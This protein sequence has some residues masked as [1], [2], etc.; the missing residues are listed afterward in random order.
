MRT[1]T[2]ARARAAR[3][4]VSCIYIAVNQRC[5]E[6]SFSATFDPQNNPLR[7]WLQTPSGGQAASGNRMPSMPL[8]MRMS[9]RKGQLQKQLTE[10]Q[11]KFDA[12]QLA[13]D[14]VHV[15]NASLRQSLNVDGGNS[16]PSAKLVGDLRVKN[17]TVRL[18]LLSTDTGRFFD[19]GSGV[20]VSGEGHVLTAAHTFL[21]MTEQFP[22]NGQLYGLRE[23][24]HVMIVVGLYQSEGEAARWRHRAELLTPASLLR[25]KVGFRSSSSRQVYIDLAVLRI[26]GDVELDP[27]TWAPSA[28]WYEA[29]ESC[30]RPRRAKSQALGPRVT[31][32]W[33]TPTLPG[34]PPHLH[35][36][37]GNAEAAHSGDE[38]VAAGW[39]SPDAQQAIYVDRS[40]LISR[41]NGFLKSRLFLHAAFSGDKPHSNSWNPMGLPSLHVPRMSPG[42]PTLATGVLLTA[43]HDSQVGRASTLAARSSASPHSTCTPTHQCCTRAG[44][45]PS[46]S[47]GRS[48]GFQWST[49]QTCGG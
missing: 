16:D 14:R 33:S 37:L 24:Q 21:A 49:C 20:L 43:V 44:S 47:S 22:R 46:R 40:H 25:R 45:D 32:V 9:T 1:V 36:P 48:M 18:G 13:Y 6:Y 27:P 42:G 11:R 34:A 19:L 31:V 17:A 7:L 4:W 15:E 12:L 10:L 26:I 8:C 3:L 23:P 29:C 30:G 5:C 35:L 38:L 39:P 28:D 41:E 2:P